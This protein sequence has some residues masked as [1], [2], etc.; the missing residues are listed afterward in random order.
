VREAAA[1]GTWGACCEERISSLFNVDKTKKK[2]SSWADETEDGDGGSVADLPPL[3]AAP[4]AGNPWKK[5]EAA[6]PVKPTGVIFEDFDVR[7]PCSFSCDGRCSFTRSFGC[8]SY[9]G[10]REG[11]TF[12]S[13]IDR[14]SSSSSCRAPRWRIPGEMAAA[15]TTAATDLAA[16]TAVATAIA[17]VNPIHRTNLETTRA[18]SLKYGTRHGSVN[19][20]LTFAT[21][22]RQEEEIATATGEEIAT[23]TAEVTP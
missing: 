19:E 20:N 3:P 22:V 16:T 9:L 1:L 13:D 8:P 6:E 12:S 17:E 5:A 21:C 18:K 14:V 2:M 15:A 11:V 23:A 4:P 7:F 10:L